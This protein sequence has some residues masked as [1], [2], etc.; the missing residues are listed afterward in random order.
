MLDIL[1]AVLVITRPTELITDDGI[2]N[3][4]YFQSERCSALIRLSLLKNCSDGTRSSC[5]TVGQSNPSLLSRPNYNR[6]NFGIC[7]P[8]SHYNKRLVTSF[9]NLNLCRFIVAVLLFEVAVGRDQESNRNWSNLSSI[10]FLQVFSSSWKD[11]PMFGSPNTTE[12]R[13]YLSSHQR[14]ILT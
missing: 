12:K 14:H 3:T 7:Y 1:S 10:F 13:Q 9:N 11:G 8:R 5:D 6:Q 2:Y 4:A